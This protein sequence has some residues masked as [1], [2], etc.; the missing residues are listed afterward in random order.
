MELY[1]IEGSMIA[2][3]LALGALSKAKMVEK[4]TKYQNIYSRG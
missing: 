3:L 4:T 1:A 2:I